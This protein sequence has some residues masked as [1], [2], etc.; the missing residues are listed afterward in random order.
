MPSPSREVKGLR[1]VLDRLEY[2]YDASHEATGTPH[3]F[4][5]YITIHN[6]SSE[7]LRMLSRKWIVRH[8]DG[9]VIVLEGD[10]IVGHTPLLAPGNTFSY[11]SYHLSGY[12]ATA[13]GSYHGID[14]QGGIV[15]V[16]IPR[17][18]L[19]IPREN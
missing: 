8:A 13:E 17:F 12:N 19:V 2:A 14:A 16:K 10:K 9:E 1:V 7:T 3:A 4:A 5:Y 18:E 15:H 11:N 6:N